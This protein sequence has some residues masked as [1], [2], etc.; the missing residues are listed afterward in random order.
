MPGFSDFEWQRETSYP[1]AAALLA[2]LEADL[3]RG[4]RLAWQIECEPGL[5]GRTA[6][7]RE[8]KTI[9]LEVARW[10][11]RARQ[12]GIRLGQLVGRVDQFHDALANARRQA[13]Q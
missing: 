7:L 8:F 6:L 10:T 5:V 2:F 12:R 11:D 3:D 13:G 4:M 9:T 1:D